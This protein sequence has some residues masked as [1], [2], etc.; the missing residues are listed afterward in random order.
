MALSTFVK[1]DGVTNLSDARYCAGMY[2]DVLGFNLEESSQKFLNPTQYEEITGWVSG[3]EFAAEFET[4][5][6]DIIQLKLEKYP[7]ITWIQHQR[8]DTLLKLKDTGKNLIFQAD[9][10]ELAH[11]ESQVAEKL[12]SEGVYLLL[13]ADH[14]KLNKDELTTIS[15]LAKS[16][17]VILGSGI[18]AF[19]VKKLVDDLGLF[20]ISLEGG[21]EIKPGLKD[22]DEL[23]DILEELE[24]E[25]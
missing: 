19:N 7:N 24:V 1:I 5:E 2:V 13:K 25:D 22:F 4:E 16:I 21:E 15:I 6:A 9:I 17:Q 8:L 3:L 10:A 20:G 23:A 14:E 11:I 12:Q 18:S